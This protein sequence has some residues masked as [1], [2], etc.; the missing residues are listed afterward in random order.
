MGIGPKRIQCES[1]RSPPSGAEV[2]RQE[3]VS[4]SSLPTGCKVQMKCDDTRWRTG[5]EVKGKLANEVGSQY[6]HTPSERGVTSIT[7]AD[8]H[9]S[10]ASSR[11]N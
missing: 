10:A 5:G 1:V 8:A 2:T 6:P 3:A 9:N 4:A 11:L 7:T